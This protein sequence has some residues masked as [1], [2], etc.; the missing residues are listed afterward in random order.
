MGQNIFNA[1]TDFTIFWSFHLLNPKLFVSRVKFFIH[2]NSHSFCCYWQRR[3]NWCGRIDRPWQRKQNDIKAPKFLYW[4]TK[5]IN[6]AAKM[7]FGRSLNSSS[8]FL[9][10]LPN[11]PKSHKNLPILNKTEKRHLTLPLEAQNSLLQHMLPQP[12]VNW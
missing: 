11:I 2:A 6:C 4:L 7:N 1:D 12:F 10:Y 3:W 8:R 9:P 5:N